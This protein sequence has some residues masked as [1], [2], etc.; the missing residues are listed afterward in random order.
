LKR[1]SII[2]LLLLLAICLSISGCQKITATVYPVDG[3]LYTAG[4]SS[5]SA[6][7]NWD[8]TGH[9]SISFTMPDGEICSGQYTTMPNIQTNYIFGT[10]LFGSYYGNGFSYYDKQYGQAMATGDKGS[11]FQFEYFVSG[12]TNH[13]YGIGKDN[14][15]N[16]YKLM[17]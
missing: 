16:T 15:G 17:W 8:G 1:Y 10:S 4:T 9:G 5:I 14:R 7:F 13:G 12:L 11:I 2:A 3:P 6:I